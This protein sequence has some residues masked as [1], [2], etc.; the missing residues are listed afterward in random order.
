MTKLAR[1]GDHGEHPAPVEKTLTLP[2]QV[3]E[4]K[5]SSNPDL[6]LIPAED[7]TIIRPDPDELP[8]YVRPSMT[9]DGLLATVAV[10][11]RGNGA[12]ID[13]VRDELGLGILRSGHVALSL[14]DSAKEG[15]VGQVA[16]R[17]DQ[18]RYRL[19]MKGYERLGVEVHHALP[20]LPAPDQEEVVPNE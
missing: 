8:D 1:I 6:V 9:S 5:H 7:A 10:L 13:E 3:E 19:T 17:G 15:Y 11:D 12:S 14:K 16:E 20:S 2:E 4:I 18:Y